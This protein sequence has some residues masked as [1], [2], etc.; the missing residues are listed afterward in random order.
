MGIPVSAK[1]LSGTKTIKLFFK[2]S[3]GG[4]DTQDPNVIIDGKLGIGTAAPKQN[5]T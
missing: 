4:G 5:S 2:D 3:P 1:T